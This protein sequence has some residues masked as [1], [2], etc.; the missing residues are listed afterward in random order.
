MQ[1]SLNLLLAFLLPIAVLLLAFGAFEERRLGR[2]AAAATMGVAVALLAYALIGFGFQ[3][4]GIGLVNPAPGLQDLTREWSPLDVMVGPGWGVVG[5]DGFGA[6]LQSPTPEMMA[7]FL[8]NAALG[9]TAMLIPLLAVAR[10]VRS[11]LVVVAA[12]LLGALVYPLAG[13]WIWG[14]GWLSQMGNASGLGHGVVDFGGSGIVFMFGGFAALGALLGSGMRKH[15]QVTTAANIPEFPK[16]QLPLLMILGSFLMLV[17]LGAAATGDPFPFKNLPS[18]LII[19]NLVSAMLA[20]ILIATLYGWFVS[21]EPLAMLA[22]R[23]AAAGMVAAA[24]SLPFIQTAGALAIGAIAGLLLPLSAFVVDRWLRVDDEGLVVSTFG[25]AGAWGLI[26]LAVFA[27]GSYGVGWNGTGVKEY[28]GVA[29][30]GVTGIFALQN[31]VPDSP[32]QMEAQF[33]GIIAIGLFAFV[34]SWLVFFLLRFLGKV[35]EG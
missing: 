16:A 23:G 35:Q 29:N 17:G 30:Q 28:L 20:G 7:L 10:R 4:G 25:A 9:G 1:T 27:D 3:F 21:G 33:F 19:F 26:A 5:L 24:A 22:A 18:T 15:T 6:L 14:G 13:N 32:G 2:A 12:L 8:F 34:I 31:F 11:R